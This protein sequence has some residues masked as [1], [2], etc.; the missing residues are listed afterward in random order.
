MIVPVPTRRFWNITFRSLHIAVFA[1]LVGGH[2][3]DVPKAALLPWLYAT[4]LTGAILTAIEI[5]TQWK[6]F[7]QGRGI[8]VLVKLG[9]LGLIPVF[10]EVRVWILMSV[11]VLASVAAHMPGRFRYYSIVYRRVLD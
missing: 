9:L 7:H 10:W 8:A 1:P 5:G 6:W 4:L 11:I 2:M 3:F